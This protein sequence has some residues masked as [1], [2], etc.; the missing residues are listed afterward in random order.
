MKQINFIKPV[1]PQAY[2]SARLW[3]RVT[4]MLVIGLV[5]SMLIIHLQTSSHLRALQ[6]TKAALIGKKDRIDALAQQH[7]KLAQEKKTLD[8]QLQQ[9][10]V[11]K[12]R[13]LK[14][15]AELSG[16]RT[17]LAQTHMQLIS[18]T[19]DAKHA[20]LSA[21]CRDARTAT[22]L[23]QALSRTCEFHGI[24]LSRLQPS[25]KITQPGYIAH[26]TANITAS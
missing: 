8:D 26:I 15:H 21:Y 24:K 17:A 12:N 5:A 7:A 3:Y 2:A 14:K 23:M 19:L 16:I 13:Q 1:T 25:K 10:T 6:Q 18:L 20:D 11:V 4:I 22:E 9:I